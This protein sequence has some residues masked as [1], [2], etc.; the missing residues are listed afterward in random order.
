MDNWS[1]QRQEHLNIKELKWICQANPKC[2]G[3]NVRREG[4]T[5]WYSFELKNVKPPIGDVY[6]VGMLNKENSCEQCG[7]YSLIKK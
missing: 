1:P 7:S 2:K 6:T 4:D 5:K 3:F